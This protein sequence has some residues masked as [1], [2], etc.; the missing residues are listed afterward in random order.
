MSRVK[1]GSTHAKQAQTRASN[2]PFILSAGV[3]PTNGPGVF[4]NRKPYLSPIGLPPTI[5][6]KVYAVKPSI[7]RTLVMDSQN[8]SSPKIRTDHSWKA[9]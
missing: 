1:C 7:R 3:S 2:T 5:V 9:A 8:S 6:M 4:Q